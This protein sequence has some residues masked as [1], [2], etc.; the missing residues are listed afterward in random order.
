M[1][2][3][4]QIAGDAANEQNQQMAHE[5]SMNCTEEGKSILDRGNMPKD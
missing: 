5:W 1:S 3:A 2:G 4:L